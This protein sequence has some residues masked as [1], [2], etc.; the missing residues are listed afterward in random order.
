MKLS[1]FAQEILYGSSLSQKLG[2][3]QL[4]DIVFDNFELESPP[5]TPSRAKAL[6]FSDKQLKFPRGKTL[7]LDNKKAMALNS[8]ANHEL[9]ATEMMAMALLR[10]PHHTE[11]LRNFK[12]GVIIS[13]LDEQ[14]H[15]KLYQRRM[16]ELGYEFGDFPLN[17]FFWR[18]NAKLKTPSQYLSVMSLTFEAANLDF[19]HYYSNIFKSFDDHKT[20]KI[21]DIVYQ[22]ELTH[23]ALGGNYL[24]RW[25]GDKSLWQYYL[26]SLPWPLTPARSKGIHFKSDHRKKARL[27]P[28]F[29]ESL[30]KYDDDFEVTS[31]KN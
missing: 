2:K 5:P 27:A 13:L 29:I 15:F 25:R 14:K 11:E 20:S 7:N 22:D 6:Q 18:Q 8:F 10:Y 31:R 16:N 3:V 17:D 19:A 26:E 28:E 12:R 1:E 30:T 9:L 23:V 4:T 24:N 21:L